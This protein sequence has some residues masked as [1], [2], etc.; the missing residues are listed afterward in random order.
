MN[1][2]LLTAASLFSAASFLAYALNCLISPRMAAEFER[3]GMATYRYPTGVLQI[4]GA[5]GLAAGRWFPAIGASAA[6]GLAL[7]ML[8]ALAV[9]I[10][11]KDGVLPSL[12]AFFYLLLNSWL[13][14]LFL[15]SN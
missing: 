3:Y 5:V 1:C 15:T 6:A 7:M 14:Y 8:A 4:S 12:P 11:I 9:R 13:V 2:D 10:K